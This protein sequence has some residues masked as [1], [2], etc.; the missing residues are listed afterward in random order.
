M[1]ELLTF[2]EEHLPGIILTGES[3]NPDFEIIRKQGF[4]FVE[5]REPKYYFNCN[6][7]SIDFYDLEDRIYSWALKTK[8]TSLTTDDDFGSAMRSAVCKRLGLPSVSMKAAILCVNKYLTKWTVGHLDSTII[9]DPDN[10][11]ECIS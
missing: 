7:L 10:I 2:K 6:D 1:N 3:D 5:F 11:D 8:V 4:K 9:I